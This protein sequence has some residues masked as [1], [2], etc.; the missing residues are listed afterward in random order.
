MGRP[1]ASDHDD[2]RQ[3]IL[4][5][6]A[7]LFAAHGYDRA[8][9]SMLARACGMSK[10]LLYYYY[11][12]KSHLLF[13][14]IL[15]HLQHLLTVT[16]NAHDSEEPRERLSRLAESLLEAYRSADS[17]H[18]VQINQMHLLPEDRQAVLKDIERVLVERFVVAIAA[19]VPAAA[20]HPAVLKP[21]TMS[22]FGMLN[23]NYVWFRD[24]GALSRREYAR[25]AVALVV[26]GASGLDRSLAPGA[27]AVM[28]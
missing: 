21:L 18:H 9:L 13:D 17:K 14:I 15:G 28:T 27:E 1:R 25:L 10:A 20:R 3:V 2:K 5:R 4:E 22:L 23:W 8:S 12:D 19:C 6:A 24:D 7:A 16:D 26:D 11:N